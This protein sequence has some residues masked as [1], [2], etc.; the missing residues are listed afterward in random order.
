MKTILINTA[1]AVAVF[2]VSMALTLG[3]I[4]I[5]GTWDMLAAMGGAL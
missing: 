1:A 4:C 3:I 5:T 2:S